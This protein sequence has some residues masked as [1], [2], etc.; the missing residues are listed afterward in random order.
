MSCF[1]YFLLEVQAPVMVSM[2][3]GLPIAE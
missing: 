1:V 2:G 3:M